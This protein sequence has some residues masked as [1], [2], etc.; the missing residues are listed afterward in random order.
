M[1]NLRKRIL[2]L[3]QVAYEEEV[4]FCVRKPIKSLNVNKK[5]KK[6][7]SRVLHTY[8]IMKYSNIKIY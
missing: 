4:L 2:K 1:K 6:V 7:C 5:I 3:S 8:A